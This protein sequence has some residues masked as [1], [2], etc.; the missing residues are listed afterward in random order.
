MNWLPKRNRTSQYKM[1]M[2]KIRSCHQISDQKTKIPH[3]IGN[4]LTKSKLTSS[5]ISLICNLSP[6]QSD[7]YHKKKENSQGHP[8]SDQTDVEATYAVAGIMLNSTTAWADLAGLSSRVA[9]SFVKKSPK[10]FFFGETRRTDSTYF[11]FESMPML[12]GVVTLDRL[13]MGN[14]DSY[15]RRSPSLQMV[16]KSKPQRF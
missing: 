11:F 7:L 14:E 5:L 15:R 2:I 12:L 4:N 9:T 16:S 13:E 10:Y 1:K 8:S 6:F 3:C